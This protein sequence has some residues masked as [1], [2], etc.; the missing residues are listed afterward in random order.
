MRGR[1]TVI[2]SG[3]ATGA[4]GQA[5]TIARALQPATIVIEDVDLIGMDRMLPGGDHNAILF[6]LLNEMDGL[7]ADA[8]VLFV[9][10]TNRVDMLEPALT[11]RPGR[12]D[13]AIEIGLPDRAARRQLLDLYL[14]PALDDATADDIAERTDGVAAA[15][16][17]ELARR[18][19]LASIRTGAPVARHRWPEPHRARRAERAGAAPIA[20]RVRRHPLLGPSTPDRAGGRRW[21]RGP[22]GRSECADDRRRPR[23]SRATCRLRARCSRRGTRRERARFA[24]LPEK[25]TDPVAAAGLVRETLRFSDGVAARSDGPAR[26]TGFLTSFDAAPDPASP[27]ARYAP[28]RGARSTSSTAMPSPSA[29]TRCRRTTHCSPNWPARALQRGVTDH[30]VHVPLGDPSIEAAWVALGFGR[31]NVVAVRDLAAISR[32]CPTDVE[33]RIATPDELDVVDRLVDE[34]AVFH[35]ASPIFR[36]YV[37][38]ATA[39]EVRRQLAAELASADHAFL[40]A[41]RA[42]RDVGVLSIGPGLGSPL[43]VPDGAAY[44]AAT[45]VLPDERGNGVGA[46]LVDAAFR[47]GGRPRSPRCVPAL[48]HGQRRLDLV[49]DR[50]RLRPGDGPSAPP[51]RRADP[52]RSPDRLSRSPGHRRQPVRGERRPVHRGHHVD[53]SSVAALDEAQHAIA[54]LRAQAASSAARPPNPPTVSRP[55]R[56]G[57]RSNARHRRRTVAG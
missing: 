55:D 12:I 5:G 56:T 28:Q 24:L 52:H 50:G 34:E 22:T 48:R 2:L 14:S 26:S 10:T 43:Y 25:Y 36:P 35:A 16:I 23:W 30:V 45:A 13:Q 33:V 31:A 1:T 46:A 38:A 57:F 4:I 47:L 21:R 40:V 8:D 18:A 11:A 32:P 6:Q 19:T 44:I 41:R 27:M 39:E 54:E 20:R 29:R 37:R 51:A 53:V 49:L 15:F 7:A 3:A 42:G 17:K 9:L